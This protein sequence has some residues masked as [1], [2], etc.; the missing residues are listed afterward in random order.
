MA[1]LNVHYF[2]KLAKDSQGNTVPVGEAGGR[3]GGQAVT[4]TSATQMTAPFPKWARFIRLLSDADAYIDIDPS[5]AATVNSMKI[6]ANVAEY[7]GL[8]EQKVR[9]GDLTLSVYDGTT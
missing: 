9:A 3:S 1:I 7:F 6:E 4:Y 8:D 5:P 2:Q